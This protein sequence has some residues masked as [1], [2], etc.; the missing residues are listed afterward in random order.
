[1]VNSSQL[2]WCEKS[3]ERLHNKT[4]LIHRVEHDEHGVEQ[5]RERELRMLLQRQNQRREEAELVPEL[6]LQV[7]EPVAAEAER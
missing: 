5:E 7:S 4:E 6:P 1:M 3:K 2:V